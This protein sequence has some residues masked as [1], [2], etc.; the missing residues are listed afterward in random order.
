LRDNNDPLLTFEGDNNV[1]LQQTSNFLLSSYEEYL[2]NKK[3]A[4]TP[5]MSVDFINNMDNIFAEK[6]NI[7]SQNELLNPKGVKNL[8]NL[9][10]NIF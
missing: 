6:F 3:L 7:Q 5:L 8:S 10:Y 4:P 9:N 2:K 1:L